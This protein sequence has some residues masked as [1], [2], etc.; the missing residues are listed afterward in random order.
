[1]VYQ[2]YY[3]IINSSRDCTLRFWNIPEGH[4]SESNGVD[5]TN[6]SIRVALEADDYVNTLQ[7]NVLLLFIYFLYRM[8]VRY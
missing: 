8:I 6:N 7:W 2:Y 3:I 1:M 5:I 4:I